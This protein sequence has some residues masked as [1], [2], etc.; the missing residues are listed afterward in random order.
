MSILTDR[1]IEIEERIKALPRGTLTY[2]TIKGRPQPYLQWKEDGKVRSRY[3]KTGER[4]EVLAQVEERKALEAELITCLARHYHI[5]SMP[6]VR[7][8]AAEYKAMS[9]RGVSGRGVS[10]GAGEK[11]KKRVA[12]G[13][14][15][16]E[17]VMERNVFYVDKTAFIKDWWDS[18]DDVTLITRPRR[19]GKTLMLNTVERFFSNRFTDQAKL[20]EGLAVWEDERF[21]EL[22]GTMPVIFFTLAAVKANT[23]AGAVR[24]ICDQ[25]RHLFWAHDYLRNSDRLTEGQRK[26]FASMSSEVSEDMIPGSINLLSSLLYSHFGQKVIILL[27]EYDTPLHEA[28]VSGYWDEAVSLMRG[29]FNATFKTNPHYGRALM[30]GITRVS[31]ESMFSDLNNLKVVSTTTD[32]YAEAFGFTENEVFDALDEYGYRDHK[33][34]RFWYDGFVFGN[35]TDIYNP[36]SILNYLQEGKLLPYWANTSSNALAGKLIAEGD[37]ALKYQFEDLMRGR[38]ILSKIDEQ[39]VFGEMAGKP[40]AV[41]SLLLATGYLKAVHVSDD[42]IYELDLTNYEVRLTF[43][44]MVSRWFTRNGDPYNPFIKALLSGDLESMNHYMN[45]VSYST[46]SYFDTGTDSG[47]SEPEKFYHGFVLGLMVDLRKRYSIT[48]NRE[49]GLGRY[50]VQLMPLDPSADDAILIEFKVQNPRKDADLE[51]AV[52]AA[53]AQIE[54]KKY[55]EAA[56]SAGIP[57]ERIR[58]YGFA[59][60]GKEVLI[61]QLMPDG[62][63]IYE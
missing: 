52:A 25:L 17:S 5:H 30:T 16:F 42:G 34:V 19:F 15:D 62:G 13:L 60:R 56:L 23:Y 47:R 9:S 1:I 26:S 54:A 10:A 55:A 46:F 11:P 24:S 28:Y 29:F 8:D 31:R 3:I 22:Q 44:N 2:K 4:D 38:T 7:E 12:V 49:S 50:D 36:W 41:W 33:A 35:I 45:R 27:D 53:L 40:E 43:E 20:F 57:D 18:G 39:I 63:I 6:E 21:R 32:M 37:I 51:D 61:G 59:F 58:R 48:S 14:Q